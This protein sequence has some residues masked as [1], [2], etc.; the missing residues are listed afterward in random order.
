MANK[1]IDSTPEID[2]YRTVYLALK[3]LDPAAQLR[4]LRYSAEMLDLKLE[5]LNPNSRTYDEQEDNPPAYPATNPSTQTFQVSEDEGISAVALKWM[6]R[7]N[8]SSKAL[9]DIFSLGID[10]IDLVTKSVPGKSKRERMLHV[11]LLKAIAAYLATGAA[12]VTYEQLKE[13][14]LHYKAF[15]AT[16][17]AAHIKSFSADV[18]G[19]KE[20]GY[21]LTPRGL[22]SAT[23]LIQQML[24]TQTKAG[25]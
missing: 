9:K 4:V 8:F 2:A 16:N 19:T 11:L 6:R 23:D 14:A 25:R 22:T 5:M 3:P 18:G 12:R 24:A 7:S 1:K 15:D 20:S 13:S 21:T 10:E 17:F